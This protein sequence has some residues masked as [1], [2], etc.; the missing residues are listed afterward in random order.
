MKLK[1]GPYSPSRLE[2]ASCGYSFFKQYVDP[3]RNKSWPESLPQARGSVVHEVFE[4]ITRHMCAGASQLDAVLVRELVVEAIARHPAAYEETDSIL[5]M[6]DGYIRRPPEILLPDSEIEVRMAIML[7]EDGRFQECSYDNPQAL[8]R[9]RADIM[10]IS[11]DY[12]HALVYDHKTQPNIET[13]DT[14]Q[15]GFYAWVIAKKNPILKEIITILH[16]A[17]Y[18][19]Y[20]APYIWL[21]GEEFARMQ[22]V[23]R[24]LNNY[25]KEQLAEHPEL[26]ADIQR[27]WEEAFVAEGFTPDHLGAGNLADIEDEIMTRIAVAERRESWEPTPHKNCQYCPVL[28]ECPLMKEL[29]E[30]DDHGRAHAKNVLGPIVDTAQAVKQAGY[31]N[32]LEQVVAE[33]KDNLKEHV[34]LYGPVAIH[35]KIY[36]FKAT[37]GVDWDKVNKA[38]KN[39][40]YDIFSKHGID[41]RQFMG[42][43]QT[44]TKS[45]WMMENEGLIKE[46]ASVLP[47][48]ASSEFRGYKA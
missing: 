27:T 24:N 25:K 23:I 14:F 34:K 41:A 37:E 43:S 13:A 22:T 4:S 18:S 39:K 44:F 31:L 7:G 35:G 20:S 26:S 46:L 32:V 30:I 15:L 9:G 38:L 28:R 3:D 45:L 6:V 47:K 17:R 11:N 29:I 1:Y 48:K 10:M 42:F 8:A 2:T 21:S 19:S 5:K 40:L 36:D 16:F 33:I 12:T